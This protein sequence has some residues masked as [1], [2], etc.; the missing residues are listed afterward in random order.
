MEDYELLAQLKRQD[1]ARAAAIIA[2]VLKGFD[3]YRKDAVAYRAAR[4]QLL[5]AADAQAK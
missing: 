1:P 5:E 2:G 3:D 4:Q